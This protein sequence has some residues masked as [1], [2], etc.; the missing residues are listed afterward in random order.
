M[1]AGSVREDLVAFIDFAPTVLSLAGAAVPPQMQGQ[2]FLGPAKA[3]A[4]KYAFSGRDRM[5]ETY[6]RIRSVRNERFRYIR[7]FNPELPYAQYINYMDEMP[8]MKVWRQ[9]AFAGRLNDV[10]KAFFARTKPAE[11]LYDLEKDPYETKNLAAS[12]EHAG[13]LNELPRPS[14]SGS[15]TPRTWAASRRR[16]SSRGGWSRTSSRA[17]T[18]PG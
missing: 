4:R 7:N 14:T 17:S 2:V 13:V 1:P 8:I 12:P 5:D 10:Q 9:W 6:D 16:S 18:T 15:W 3:P 11:E